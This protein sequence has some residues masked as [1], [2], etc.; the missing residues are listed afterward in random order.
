MVKE[1]RR[2]FRSAAW[3]PGVL[4]VDEG[5]APL[6]ARDI[7]RGVEERRRVHPDGE[8]GLDE[9]LRG[10]QPHHSRT[11]HRDLAECGAGVLADEIADL[12]GAAPAHRDARAAVPVVVDDEFRSHPLHLEVLLLEPEGASAVWTNSG[13]ELA[14]RWRAIEVRVGQER[15]AWTC[16][17]EPPC[18]LERDITPG[19]ALRGTSG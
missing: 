13:D 12:D 8:A 2:M 4:V 5:R 9:Q 6:A 19:V 15:A 1:V 16:H 10:G 11:Q 14:V 3:R 18:D 17:L 7:G